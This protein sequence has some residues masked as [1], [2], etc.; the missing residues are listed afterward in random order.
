MILPFPLFVIAR[1]AESKS[2]QSHTL[3]PALISI[4]YN[5]YNKKYCG[6]Q[7]MRLPRRFASRSDREVGVFRIENFFVHYALGIMCFHFVIA[8]NSSSL[9]HC[10]TC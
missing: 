9:C 5:I 3:S 10:E 2:W 7:W 6:L 4:P 1:L 8:N